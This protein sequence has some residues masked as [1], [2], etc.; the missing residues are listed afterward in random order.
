MLGLQA[1]N[2]VLR[3][4]RHETGVH[5]AAPKQVPLLAVLCRPYVGCGRAF[6]RRRRSHRVMQQA[7]RGDAA[8]EGGVESVLRQAEPAR[9]RMHQDARQPRHRQVVVARRRAPTGQG[10][11]GR[12]RCGFPQR[13]AVVD[14]RRTVGHIGA[15]VDAFLVGDQ[16]VLQR[17]PAT[18]HIGARRIEIPAPQLADL[19]R[20]QVEQAQQPAPLRRVQGGPGG[21]PGHDQHAGGLGG[22]LDLSVHL[23]TRRFVAAK[24][25]AHV[26]PLNGM[27]THREPRAWRANVLGHGPGPAAL[28]QPPNWQRPPRQNARPPAP[29]SP[30][31]CPLRP[32]GAGA[33][34]RRRR[35]RLRTR[36]P[37]CW[38]WGRPAA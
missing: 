34:H 12:E 13:V 7:Q 9:D 2:A 21:Q 29:G 4:Q 31:S 25:G 30:R 37:G 38:S 35:V 10:L 32:S 22:Q 36:A 8:V 5:M 27:L 3:Q 28:M 20:R 1:A 16:P 33:R 26:D 19:V 17:E 11:L 23:R 6:E 24:Q 18:V 14:H 15:H